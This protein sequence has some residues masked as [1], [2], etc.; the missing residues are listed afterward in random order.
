MKTII[1][2]VSI[3]LLW[4]LFAIAPKIEPM[5]GNVRIEA[6]RYYV[7]KIYVV[8]SEIIPTKKYSIGHPII[9]TRKRVWL[10]IYVADGRKIILYK[11]INAKLIPAKP[12]VWE[13]EKE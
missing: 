8:K 13:F 6:F 2:L 9:A 7:G 5:T 12:E 1:L 11:I 3:V 4:P 10:E